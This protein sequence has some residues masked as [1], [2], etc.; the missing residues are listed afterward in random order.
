VTEQ[1]IYKWRKRDNVEGCSH[2]PHR[3]QTTLTP[4][5][6]AIAVALHKTLFVSFDDPLAVVREFLKGSSIK[7][8]N[9]RCNHDRPLYHCPQL[10]RPIKFAINCRHLKRTTE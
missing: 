7:R 5:Q 1:T 6:E 10:T 8:V 2:T 4:A 9:S 3:L